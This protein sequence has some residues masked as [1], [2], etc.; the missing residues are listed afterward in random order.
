MKTGTMSKKQE[1]LSDAGP[2][3]AW[4]SLD[5]LGP[6]NPHF[7]SWLPKAYQGQELTFQERRA[8]FDE[9]MQHY[10]CYSNDAQLPDAPSSRQRLAV[11]SLL[12]MYQ[13]EI[14]RTLPAPSFIR[15]ED[16]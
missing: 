9:L 5:F 3:C 2:S 14:T 13:G 11:Q 12:L 8:W 1:A 10:G 4:L 7:P 16:C 15:K 6:Q